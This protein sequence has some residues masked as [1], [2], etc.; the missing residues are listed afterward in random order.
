MSQDPRSSPLDHLMRVLPSLSSLRF[1][2]LENVLGFERSQAR[3]LVVTSLAAA[4][5]SLQEFL[6]CPRQI[7][8]PNS[9]LRYYL[10]ARRS[11]DWSFQTR[12]D[13]I[14]ELSCLQHILNTMEIVT[15]P[16]AVKEFLLKQ[17]DEDTLLPEKV[18]AKHA[19]V[20]DIIRED[21]TVSCCFTAGY[22]RFGLTDF[23]EEKL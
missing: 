6:L 17:P 12:R 8:V 10:L 16:R 22:F 11:P 21:S 2:L 1:F 7:G 4:G 5:F 14:T 9:R 13:L 18:L 3:E 20:L 15:T 23:K 19:R